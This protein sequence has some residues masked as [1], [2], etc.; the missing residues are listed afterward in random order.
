M[1]NKILILKSIFVFLCKIVNEVKNSN[2]INNNEAIPITPSL[3]PPFIP[4]P[5]NIHVINNN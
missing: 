5:T 2:M 1:E 3:I 4:F